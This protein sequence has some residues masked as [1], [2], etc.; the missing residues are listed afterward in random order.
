[1][2]N[3]YAKT[4][5]NY[6]SVTDVEQFKKIMSSCNGS[7]AIET[8]YEKQSDGSIKYG[9][10]CEGSIKGL[11][12]REDETGNTEYFDDD[13]VDYNYDALCEALQQI[14]P[15]NDAI[16]ITEVG[17]EKMRY[18]TGICAVITRDEIQYL[19]L[20]RTAVK[21]AAEMLENIEFTTKNYY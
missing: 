16:I 12:E 10:Y 18:L 21:L 14:L 8:F 7:D 9:F 2:G 1:M 6:F 4:R 13:D 17:S 15:D 3:Y 11:P 20:S 19:D 5:T